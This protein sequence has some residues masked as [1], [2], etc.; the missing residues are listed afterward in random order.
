MPLARQSQLA[1]SCA[2]PSTATNGLTETCPPTFVHHQKTQFAK[3]LSKAAKVVCGALRVDGTV[4]LDAGITS[5]R[6]S[7]DVDHKSQN[8]STSSSEDSSTDHPHGYQDKMPCTILALSTTD[9]TV[10]D[11]AQPRMQVPLTQKTLKRLLG[12]YPNGKIFNLE[13]SGA[14]YSG[15]SSSGEEAD[16]QGQGPPKVVPDAKPTLWHKDEFKPI[17]ELFAGARSVALVPLWDPSRDRFYACG[18]VWSKTTTRILTQE[19]DLAY[20]KALG[21]VTMA[22]INRIDIALANKAKADLLDTVSHELRSP[23]HGILASAE[24][25]ADSLLDP[26]QQE[27]VRA[28]GISGRTLLYTIDHLLVYSKVNNISRSLKKGNRK[29]HGFYRVEEEGRLRTDPDKAVWMQDV[30]LD[31]LAEEVIETVFIGHTFHHKSTPEGP[32]WAPPDT[33]LVGKVQVSVDIDHRKPWVF[34]TIPGAI[35]RVIMNIFGNALKYTPQGHVTIK[36]EQKEGKS[37]RRST[38]V[39][40]TVSDTGKGISDEFLHNKLFVPFSQEDSLNVGMGLGLSIVKRIATS[41]GGSVSVRSH[42]GK[43][44]TVSVS[45][46]M[47]YGDVNETRPAEDPFSFDAKVP[48]GLRVA[49]VGFSRVRTAP[50]EVSS[51]ADLP[52][53]SLPLKWFNMT[54]CEAD[55]ADPPDVIIYSEAAFGKLDKTT[56]TSH[57]VPAVVICHNPDTALQLDTLFPKTGSA[58]CFEF[59]HQPS[60]PRKFGSILASALNRGKQLRETIGLNNSPEDNETNGPSP[61]VSDVN[62]EWPCVQTDQKDMT[63]H[64]PFANGGSQKTSFDLT[65]QSLTILDDKDSPS[66]STNGS[67]PKSP[68]IEEPLEPQFLLILSAYMKKLSRPFC[69]AINGLEALKTFQSDPKRFCCVFMDINMPIMDGL[70]STRQIREFEREN[71]LTPITI[72]A[73]TGLATDSARNEAFASGMDVFLTRPVG[74]RQLIPVLEEKVFGGIEAGQGPES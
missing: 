9:Q 64:A 42:I 13:E 58:S 47:V 25:L 16:T 6:G 38:M 70:E 48:D 11:L 36:L 28:L 18:F 71:H 35:C 7:H 8:D 52:L 3:V 2:S 4:F 17:A 66:E 12:R 15:E 34:R 53:E 10:S 29:H 63:Q 24:L 57:A 74:L 72:I 46:P 61:L 27:V 37:S 30:A 62:G 73:I 44:T 31:Q 51:S 68:T 1:R 20:L 67:E 45:L 50:G 60:T 33:S 54:L 55:S 32:R 43:G 41:L 19:A 56:L 22:E 5:P 49:A 69:T 23:L 26:L 65:V 40:L 21:I 14:L 59:I 39:V